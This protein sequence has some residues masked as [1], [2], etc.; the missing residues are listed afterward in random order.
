MPQ[1]N[2][3]LVILIILV[4]WMLRAAVYVSAAPR[5]FCWRGSL[6][7][8][9]MIWGLGAKPAGVSGVHGASRRHWLRPSARFLQD[10]WPGR[11]ELRADLIDR[12]V[13]RGAAHSGKFISLPKR[14]RRW[15]THISF[16]V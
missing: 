9:W 5:W 10:G 4:V 12:Q 13:W 16:P 3:T 1:V 11:A 15:T 8:A 7:W 2:C 14:A 6:N